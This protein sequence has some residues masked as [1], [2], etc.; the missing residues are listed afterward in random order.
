MHWK[1][2]LAG[3]LAVSLCALVPTRSAL[4]QAADETEARSLHEAGAAAFADGR[5]EAALA[6][7]LESYELSEAPE[8]LYNIATAHDRL[9]HLA[10]AA[11]YY[12]RYLS[13]LPEAANRNY[14]ERRLEV[15]EQLVAEREGDA[16]GSD[17]DVEATTDG[18]LSDDAATTT[19]SGPAPG[20]ET[21]A[22]EASAGV[23]VGAIVV[24]GLGLA[25]L[26]GALATGLL[27]NG[28]HADLEAQCTPEGICP[29][30]AQSDIDALQRYNIS[31][32]VLLAV[33][34]VMVLGGVVGWIVKSLGGAE[35]ETSAVRVDL[36]PA[37]MSVSGR[38]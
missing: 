21:P 12:Q 8:L 15:L 25:V 32:D 6:R 20:D 38:F 9:G 11:D 27:S 30:E 17:E 31:T 5:F 29:A 24:A 37:G 34:G 35:D 19:E 3:L 28:A 36:G 33:G 13:A 26:G 1:L 14:V 2:H 7:W 10:E 16:P 22:E 23:P 4:A 18:E